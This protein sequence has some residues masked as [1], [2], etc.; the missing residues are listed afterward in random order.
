MWQH[1]YFNPSKLLF[2][3]FNS[4]MG[5][6]MVNVIENNNIM[7]KYWL[8]GTSLYSCLYL[9]ASKSNRGNNFSVVLEGPLQEYES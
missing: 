1:L 4:V 3:T 8:W 5:F 2:E 6:L 7:V 9:I